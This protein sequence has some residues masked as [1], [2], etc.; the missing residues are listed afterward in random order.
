MEEETKTN[1]DDIIIDNDN[2]QGMPDR[3][4]KRGKHT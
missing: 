3:V 1:H 2:G 4:K